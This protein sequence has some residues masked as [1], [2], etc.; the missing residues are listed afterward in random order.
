MRDGKVYKGN[1]RAVLS[2]PATPL[3][4]ET[5]IAEFID[6]GNHALRARSEAI[7]VKSKSREGMD[8]PQAVTHRPLLTRTAAMRTR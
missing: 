4:I 2:R 6:W 5:L 8:T 1:V 3:P 7:E